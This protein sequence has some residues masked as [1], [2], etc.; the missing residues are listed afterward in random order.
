KETVLASSSSARFSTETL[1][2]YGNQVPEMMRHL[3]RLAPEALCKV[4][5]VLSG[6]DLDFDACVLAEVDLRAGVYPDER[7]YVSRRRI[8][9]DVAVVFLLDLSSSTAERIALADEP[10][11]SCTCGRRRRLALT[12]LHGRNYRRIIDV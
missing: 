12:K 2:A 1:R 5:H 9:R 3:Y 6:D 11:G 7:F 4:G 8:Q 10:D